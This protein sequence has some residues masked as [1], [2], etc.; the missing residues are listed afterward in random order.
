[1]CVCFSQ[2]LHNHRW[3]ILEGYKPEAQNVQ[4]AW[5]TSC[6]VVESEPFVMCPSGAHASISQLSV[7][8]DSSV[9]NNCTF[10]I[11]VCQKWQKWKPAV[12]GTCHQKYPVA[13][14]TQDGI[15]CRF[16]AHTS[17]VVVHVKD[18]EVETGLWLRNGKT[19]GG[20]QGTTV[21]VW[22][23]VSW[24][25]KQDS[26]VPLRSSSKLKQLLSSIC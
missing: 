17:S 21:C 24:K 23:F 4:K 15:S 18:K 2:H 19:S 16:P 20:T 6:C 9:K 3:N 22:L 8:S 13:D 10:E 11:I 25:Q 1:M 14:V 5:V 26:S 7:L 12:S